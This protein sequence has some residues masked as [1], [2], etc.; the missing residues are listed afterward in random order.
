[1]NISATPVEAYRQTNDQSIKKEAGVKKDNTD[2]QKVEQSD[3]V[4]IPGRRAAD[5]LSIKLE[6][7][8]SLLSQVLSSEEKDLLVKYFAR[9]GDETPDS[10]LYSLDARTKAAPQ[11]GMRVDVRG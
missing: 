8:P 6:K 9:F 1:M 7:S 10:Q 5:T 4:T 2:S 3:K 11:I